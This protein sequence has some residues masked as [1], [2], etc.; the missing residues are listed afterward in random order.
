MGNNPNKVRDLMNLN[1]SYVYFKLESPDMAIG[2][3][4]VPLT[5]MRSVAVDHSYYSLG[6]PFWIE[7]DHISVPDGYFPRLMIAQDIGGA[8]KGPIRGDVFWGH[9]DLAS[10]LASGMKAEGAWTI[11]VPRATLARAETSIAAR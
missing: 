3:H 11:L 10:T 7:I 4:D 5:P 6:L 2:A 1:E 8:I 9:G